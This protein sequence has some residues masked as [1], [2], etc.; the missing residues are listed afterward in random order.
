VP[1][2]AALKFLRF[3]SRKKSRNGSHYTCK[4]HN[5]VA[6]FACDLEREPISTRSEPEKAATARMR[7][8][9][10]EFLISFS[11]SASHHVLEADFF[12]SSR[13]LDESFVWVERW[14][15]ILFR[16]SEGFG[17]EVGEIFNFVKSSISL[18]TFNYPSSEPKALD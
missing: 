10:K 6:M 13:A 12:N 14:K 2:G 15:L 1:P 17:S 16:V 11:S 18:F 9:L 5:K 7:R 4:Q 3:D 8:D